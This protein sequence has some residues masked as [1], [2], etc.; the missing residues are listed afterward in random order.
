[1]S[2]WRDVPID[3]DTRQRL[4]GSVVLADTGAITIRL[5]YRLESP[6][7]LLHAHWRVRTRDKQA[8]R[9][10]L[11][12][13]I[14]DASGHTTCA[15]FVQ[16]VMAL[17]LP[18]VQD[19]RRVQVERLVPSRRNFIKDD[20]N[21]VYA[22][23]PLL[24]QIRGCGFLR[25]DARQWTELLPPVQRVSDD[26]RDWTVI[27]IT[28]MEATRTMASLFPVPPTPVISARSR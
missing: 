19:K 28:P 9:R 11:E 4:R 18:P 13:A 8:W 6:N 21:L 7:K 24:D 26:G 23:K 5:P 16:P 12:R 1:V 27:T 2:S 10:R 15:G 20:D 25:D 3:R 17:G 14:A 22:Q